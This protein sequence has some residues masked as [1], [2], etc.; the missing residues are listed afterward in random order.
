V[1]AM[2]TTPQNH[3]KYWENNFFLENKKHTIEEQGPNI[4]LI[5][6]NLL[7]YSDHQIKNQVK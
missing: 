6:V 2:L 5:A 4:K 1:E 3:L 7:F